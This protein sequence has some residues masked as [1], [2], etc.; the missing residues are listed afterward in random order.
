VL[1]HP[2]LELPGGGSLGGS[3]SDVLGRLPSES[4]GSESDGCESET[5]SE[6]LSDVLYDVLPDG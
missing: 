6:L 4:D 2:L 1:L 3:E 5:L